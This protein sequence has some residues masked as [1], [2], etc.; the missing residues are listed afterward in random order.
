GKSSVFNLPLL[1][2]LF[3]AL[4][5]FPVERDGSD[6]GP[7]RAS[8]ALLGEGELLAV[9]PEGTRQHGPTIQP[10]QPGAAYLSLR[11]GAPIVPIGLAG[12]EEI[13]RSGRGPLPRFGRGAIVA[14]PP[15][16]PPERTTRAVPRALVDE[17]SDELRVALQSVF[18]RANALRSG[19]QGLSTTP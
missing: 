10:L 1:G 4:G 18:D 12:T 2:S 13:L 6:F 14:G 8:L 9:Y 3:S 15:I 16:T 17:L 11:S 5:S 19:A 7:V